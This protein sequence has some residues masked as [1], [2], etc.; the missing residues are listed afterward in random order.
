MNLKSLKKLADS[1]PPSNRMPVLFVGHGV[2]TN[3]I[4]DNIYTR[5]WALMGKSLPRPKA[6]LSISAH[7]Q[8]AGTRVTAMQNPKTI[9]D[10]YGF[11]KQLFDVQYPAP[12]SPQHA[13]MVTKSVGKT[14]VELDHEWGLDHGTW[15]VLNQMYP[16]ADI[17]T[18][19]LSLNTRMSPA[20]H[21]ELAQEL[22]ALRLKGVLIMGSGNIVH[23][24]S[25]ARFDMPGAY[26]WAIEFDSL[27]EKFLEKGDH[28]SLI[29]YDKLGKAANLSI[30]TNEHYLP[31]LY[32]AGL[33]EDGE[34]PVFYNTEN[35]MGAIS[36]RSF[37]FG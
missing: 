36:M 31:L 14:E 25:M 26:D 9:H 20:D 21:Y 6:I 13:E 33:Q 11:P 4:E 5:N 7:W 28:Q 10:F 23:N 3:A 18:L 2:P 24:L 22:R 1:L 12:G 34:E 30:P 37:Q 17:P 16:K 19:Q 15:S 27:V 35:I 29:N 32:V 8:T